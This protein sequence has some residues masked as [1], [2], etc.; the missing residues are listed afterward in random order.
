MGILGIRTF[1]EMVVSENRLELL[2]Y[3]ASLSQELPV[4]CPESALEARSVVLSCFIVWSC[5]LLL[6]L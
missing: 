4:P 5:Y 2:F 6:L 3:M 1:L